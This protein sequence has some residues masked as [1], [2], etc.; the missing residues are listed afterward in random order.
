MGVKRDTAAR[1]SAPII[2][3]CIT[4][5]LMKTGRGRVNDVF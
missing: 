2:A 5:F 1:T 4:G 3:K